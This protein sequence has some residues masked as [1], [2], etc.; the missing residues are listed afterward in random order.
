VAE[1]TGAATELRENIHRARTDLQASS[2]RTLA[3]AKRV[4]E[5]QG[6]LTLLNDIADQTSLLAL[7]AAIEAA[8]AG[9]AGRA[10]AVVADEVRRLA[11]RSKA[12]AAQ[13]ARLAEGAQV[14]S[15][16]A[17]LAIAKRGQQLDDWMRMTGALAAKGDEAQPA[18]DRHLADTNKLGQAMLQIAE[19]LRSSAID[20]NETVFISGDES[21]IT[22]DA[23]A[24]R[25]GG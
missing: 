19:G 22:A 12:A 17:V 20:A 21:P 8:R 5:I 9:Q 7:N 16:Q 3:N 13:I 23:Q 6:V 11:E 14:T 10:F 24:P 1:L 18:V 2:D 4:T 15:A 25:W